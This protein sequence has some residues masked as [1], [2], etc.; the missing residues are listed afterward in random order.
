MKKTLIC[1]LMLVPMGLLGTWGWRTWQH[2][3]EIKI[4]RVIQLAYIDLLRG[5][6]WAKIDYDP[7]DFNPFSIHY[8]VWKEK[9]AL[10][11]NPSQ[12][13]ERPDSPR[14][15]AGLSDNNLDEKLELYEDTTNNILN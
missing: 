7:P 13:K 10:G 9:E 14:R 4:E 6:Y 12:Y 15:E 3:K 1:V 8:I 5:I 11:L 2:Q